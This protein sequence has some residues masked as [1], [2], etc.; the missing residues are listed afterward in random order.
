[1]STEVGPVEI[2][3]RAHLAE[4]SQVEVSKD[5]IPRGTDNVVAEMEPWRARPLDSVYP[6]VLIDA[7]F[8]KIREGNVVNR[9]DL[10]GG[11]DRLCQ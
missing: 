1:V 9:P 5:L 8:M 10:R 7:L 6:V 2:A 11:R 3:V 4:I